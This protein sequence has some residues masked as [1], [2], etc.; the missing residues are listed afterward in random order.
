MQGPAPY[1]GASV[2]RALCP[3]LQG[4]GW[5]GMVFLEMT[6]RHQHHPPPTS[7]LKGE[8]FKAEPAPYSGAAEAA[9]LSCLWEQL[10]FAAFALPLQGEGW[11]GMVFLEMTH[12]YQH[13]P[14]QPPP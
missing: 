7:P 9:M 8:A 3:P 5:V 14:L 4:E 12:R 11:V 2:L 1:L 6:H 10:S 13:H